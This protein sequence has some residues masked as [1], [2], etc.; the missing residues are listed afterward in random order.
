MKNIIKNNLKQKIWLTGCVTLLF[1][2][3]GPM[4]LLMSYENEKKF[5]L[6]K[7]SLIQAMERFFLPNIFCDFVP[8]IIACAVIA[9]V[10]FGYLFSKKQ[11]DLYHS[12]PVNR[13]NLFICN[14]ISGVIVYLIALFVDNVLCIFV[15]IPNQFMSATSWKNLIIAL[16]INIVHFLFGYSVT[17]IGI[18]LTGNV[19]TA[20][21]GTA[22]ISLFFPA[23]F[24]IS[25][26]LEGY[27]YVTYSGNYSVNP[28][29]TVKYSWLSPLSSY[30]TII[31]RCSNMNNYYYIEDSFSVIPALIMPLI[32]TIVAVVAGYLIYTKRPS[33]AAGR[34]IAFSKLRRF[35]EIPLVI[36]CGL[37]GVVF[38]TSS[39]NTYKSVWVWIG[40]ILGVLLSHFVLEVI[41]NESFKSI[42][43][44]KIQLLCTLAATCAIV[45]VFFFDMTGY[46]KF[47]PDKNKVVSCGVYFD[48][49]D[50]NLN[51]MEVS[52]NV[53]N[54]GFYEVSYKD[55]ATYAFANRFT[56]AAIIE[57]IIGIASIGTTCV[58][59]MIEEKYNNND[60]AYYYERDYYSKASAK[61][62]VN[63]SLEDSEE[64]GL[65]YDEEYKKAKQWMEMNGIHKLENE[66]VRKTSIRVCYELN[67][68][69]I[70][71]RYYNI[72]LSK[73]LSA[74]NEVYKT[75]EYKDVHF[76][77]D[78]EFKKDVIHKVDVYDGFESK[79]VSVTEDEKDR[80]LRTYLS[81][82]KTM[83]IDTISNVPIGRI[84]PL[85][86]VSDVY[87][88]TFSGYYIYPEFTKTI[89]LIKSYGADTK[90]LTNEISVDEL[91]S[92]GVNAYNRYGYSND[93]T[94]YVDNLTYDI[95]NDAE[96][97]KEFAPKIIN[98]NNAWTNNLLISEKTNSDNTGIDISATIKPDKGI[99]KYCSLIIKDGKVPERIDKD[100]VIGIYKENR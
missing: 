93:E 45:L 2:L 50:T 100:I 15:A 5:A 88:E 60:S 1:A 69:K 53:N 90:Y 3:V 12:I 78:D 64:E 57:K 41:I 91:I 8:T 76:N 54:N 17:I 14:Y 48:D 92:I 25:K 42:L 13:K 77:L 94:L 73:V 55:G 98:S 62:S 32:M 46:D 72:P 29:L 75:E 27:F 66:N 67:G 26:Y 87:D 85:V 49:I 11:V 43:S 28:A 82:L 63:I 59:D 37:L 6:T 81:E 33:E 51:I 9:V 34:A 40:L 74:I 24:E 80:L 31:D 36:I 52:E 47:I 44:H 56:D 68:G 84:A 18:M 7:E 70:V 96:F 20:V 79:I 38:T 99:Q 10:F 4:M 19:L 86:K 71:T 30:A 83:D 97:L 65:S 16:L 95:E 39:V 89:D 58:D 22:A 35:I 23:V 21:G 61:E